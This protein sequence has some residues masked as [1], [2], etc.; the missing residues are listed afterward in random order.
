MDLD[1]KFNTSLQ[2]Y[3][4]VPMFKRVLVANRGEIATRI[5]RALRELGITSIGIYSEADTTSMHIQIADEAYPIGPADPASSYLDIDRL[6]ECAKS[7]NADAIHPGYGFLSENPKLARACKDAGIGFIGP[8][9][10]AMEKLSHK[11]Y[12]KEAMAEAG[13]QKAAESSDQNY[14]NG[15]SQFS[16]SVSTLESSAAE[17]EVALEGIKSH[18]VDAALDISNGFIPYCH[19]FGR[20]YSDQH[21]HS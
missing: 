19:L 2:V 4:S 9:A 13:I 17:F 1:I 12:S 5:I 6:I 3:Q 20:R 11:T 15:L 16:T 21:R 18:L 7:A 10:E 8:P 14:E